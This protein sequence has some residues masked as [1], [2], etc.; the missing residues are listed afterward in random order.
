MLSRYDCMTINSNCNHY[1]L[2]GFSPRKCVYVCLV[3]AT[4]LSVFPRHRMDGN[5]SE[6]LFSL[7]Q[8][9]NCEIRF[10]LS[11]HSWKGLAD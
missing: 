9:P 6:T 10:N 4:P 2:S 3:S 7:Q 8:S 1:S 11:E 5:S